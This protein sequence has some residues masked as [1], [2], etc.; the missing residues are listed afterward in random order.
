L[1][2]QEKYEKALE[3]ADKA[4]EQ[5]VPIAKALANSVR[6]IKMEILAKTKQ[7]DELLKL[8][9]QTIDYNDSLY[10]KDLAYQLD[11]LHTKYEVD[12]HIREK[13]YMR[14]YIYISILASILTV[15]IL[16]IWVRYSHIINRKNQGLMQRI[17]EQDA[18]YAELE[19]RHEQKFNVLTSADENN[20]N[21]N[22]DINDIFVRLNKLVKERKLF[23]DKNISRQSVANELCISERSLYD[24]IKSHTG[25]TFSS[26]I[27]YMRL[28]YA[29]QKLTDKS[30]RFTMESIAID[31]GFGSRAT[32]YRLFKENY[33][34]SPDEYRKL[35]NKTPNDEP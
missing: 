19:R 27:A 13:K 23:A 12:K 17:S 34:L 15:I 22:D 4:I 6:R 3:M 28:A 21:N 9:F 11:E 10:H 14:N 25:L 2:G 16:M 33:G 26:Y 20:N 30:N 18:M 29:R 31:A 8:A 7:T 5:T 1:A 32:F 35:V 24:C